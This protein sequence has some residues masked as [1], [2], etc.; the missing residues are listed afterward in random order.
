MGMVWFSC[1]KSGWIMDASWV[2]YQIEVSS[3]ILKWLCALIIRSFF[4]ANAGLSAVRST[5][6]SC[7]SFQTLSNSP[8]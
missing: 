7:S 1:S 8:P 3:K 5:P 4:S 6:S 2:V